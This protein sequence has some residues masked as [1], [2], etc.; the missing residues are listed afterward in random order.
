M[1]YHITIR[2]LIKVYRQGTI[3]VTALRG[4][5]LDIERGEFISIMGPSGSGKSTLMNVIGGISIPTAGSIQV[6]DEEISTYS[7]SQLASYRRHKIGF[8]WQFANLLPDLN[9][10]DNIRLAMH[11]AGKFKK[12][13]VKP[14]AEKLLEDVGLLQRADHRI[15]QVSG[16]ELQRASLALALANDPEIVLADEPTGELDTMTG[17]MIME[18]LGD[19]V[20]RYG[21][22]MIIVTHSPE[23]GRMTD[24][25]LIIQ[26]GLI[27]KES[28]EQVSVDAKGLL[29]LPQ[30]FAAQF[31]GKELKIT[32][33]RDGEIK[34]TT[35]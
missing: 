9:V 3:E 18:L 30:D 14:R 8:M 22:T 31:A 7:Q 13:E 23:V 33:T 17:D 32:Q 27:V 4:I 25:T 21:K 20:K 35:T 6:D 12:S 29:Q 5:N 2:N 26:D 11:A 1:D 28:G 34:L 19:L 16:G 15:N 10:I 24:R